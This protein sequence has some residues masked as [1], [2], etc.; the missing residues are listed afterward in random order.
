MD[1]LAPL[2]SQVL[3]ILQV[4]AAGGP[5]LA[6]L[7]R[8][9]L[10]AQIEATLLETLPQGVLLQLPGGQELVA[11]GQLPF[12]EGSLLALQAQPLPGGAGIHLQVLRATPP[13]QDP[14]LAPLAQGEAAPLMARLQNPSPD[15][16]PLLEAFQAAAQPEAAAKPE[17]W[18]S[19]LKAVL[20]TLSDPAVSP[21][22]APFHL[23]QAQDGTALFEVPL[24]WAPQ[25]EPL[26]LWVEADAPPAG[27]EAVSHRVFLSVPFSAL[28]TVRVGLE[29]NPAGF[30]ARIWLQDPGRM[31]PLRAD[32]ESGLASLGAPA[33]VR[34]LPLPDPAPDLRALAGAPPLAALG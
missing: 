10:P 18:T 3:G 21:R 7:A 28:G 17:T 33:T 16:R 15:L 20:T 31:E 34:L 24:P 32:L 19:L 11:Q 5:A 22:E 26:R 27:Q 30:Q 12:P 9:A 4:P 1:P 2:P 29:R 13:P 23:L 14:V 25:G 6:A 8:L